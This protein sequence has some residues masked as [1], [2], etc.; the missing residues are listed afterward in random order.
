M[1]ILARWKVDTV[2]ARQRLGADQNRT[3]G[4][5]MG[6]PFSSA[7]RHFVKPSSQLNGD[8]KTRS[9]PAWGS[10]AASSRA[11]GI[12]RKDSFIWSSR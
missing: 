9:S 6:S 3:G 8:V 11:Y 5:E 10:I 2:K 7:A 12:L 4:Q 1:L